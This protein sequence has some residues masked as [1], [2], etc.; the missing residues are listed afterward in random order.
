[1]ERGIVAGIA[2]S[3]FALTGCFTVSQTEFPSVA[4]SQ[5]SE[6][7]PVVALSG[8]EAT[9]TTYTP[10]Y[11][12]ATV[13]RHEPG[14]Y[15]RHGRYYPGWSG[16]ETVSTTTYI[17]KTSITTAYVEKAQDTLEDSGFIVGSTNAAYTVDV[18]F[19]GPV[20]TDGDRT[21]S[22]FTMLFTLFTADRADA[23]WSARLRV[24]ENATG[25]AVLAKTYEQQ[26]AAVVWGP[27][28]FFSPLC[29]DAMN[30]AYIQDWCLS[31]LTGRA[32]SDATALLSTIHAGEGR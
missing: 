5:A 4:N 29:A 14:Y 18:S 10:V 26:Y 12:Y 16:P 27:L 22:F 20:V 28:P 24:V 3:A 8:F 17:P 11:G 25:R 31:A 32:M 15:G 21:A 23:V 19:S 1:M 6:S 2:L 13:W 9:V 7:A 30:D